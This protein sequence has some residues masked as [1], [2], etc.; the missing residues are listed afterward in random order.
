MW[1]LWGRR[2]SGWRSSSQTINYGR[3]RCEKR[4]D[5]EI[6]LDP[7]QITVT[8]SGTGETQ[9][10]FLEAK[11]GAR[12]WLPGFRQVIHFRATSA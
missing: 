12:I 3:R 11:Y 8:R 10:V 1:R 6:A 7:A 9:M 2:A 4:Q 5:N